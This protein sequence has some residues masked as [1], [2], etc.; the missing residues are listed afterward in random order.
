MNYSKLESLYDSFISHEKFPVIAEQAERVLQHPELDEKNRNVGNWSYN[1]M[2]LINFFERPKG[3]LCQTFDHF[4][5]LVSDRNI[6]LDLSEA[7]NFT[8][9]DAYL[10]W[11]YNQ[12]NK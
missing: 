4:T 7:P 11:L 5:V 9:R 2:F 12:L 8:D 3:T 10:E 6:V 1:K